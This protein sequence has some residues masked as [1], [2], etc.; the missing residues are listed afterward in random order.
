MHPIFPIIKREGEKLIMHPSPKE[1]EEKS[2]QERKLRSPAI[3]SSYSKA[4]CLRGEKW[5]QV[6]KSIF[7]LCLHKARA[8]DQYSGKKTSQTSYLDD[9]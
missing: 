4:K 7:V 8:T 3:K 1:W 5:H 6:H 9:V 2:L